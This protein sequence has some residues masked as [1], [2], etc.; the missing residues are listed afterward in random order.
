MNNNCKENN[1]SCLIKG[2]YDQRSDKMISG[3]DSLNLR[4]PEF[5]F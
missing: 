4:M 3:F 2:K 1:V 5:N